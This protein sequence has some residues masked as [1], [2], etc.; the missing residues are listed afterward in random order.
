MPIRKLCISKLQILSFWHQ[1]NS[2]IA[3]SFT[4]VDNLLTKGISPESNS[5]ALKGLASKFTFCVDVASMA[6]I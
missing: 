2:Y 6:V 1:Y 3:E 4:G 5:G